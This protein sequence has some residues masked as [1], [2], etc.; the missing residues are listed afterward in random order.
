MFSALLGKKK[1]T[2]EKL[3]NVLVNHTIETAQAIYPIVAEHIDECPYFERNP[4]MALKRDD[5]FLLAIITC[6]IARLPKICTPGQDKRLAQQL[7]EKFAQTLGMDTI[8]LGKEI[9]SCKSLMSRLNMPSKNI[10]YGLPRAIFQYYELNPFQ[11][12]YF[13]GMKVPNP[14]ILK[15][16]NG[17]LEP[18]IWDMAFLNEEFRVIEK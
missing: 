13:R 16:L 7:L 6:N 10:V 17:L 12:P 15:E 1:L 2:E 9:R 11:E 4:E 8:D 18:L 3:C 14:L 5:H